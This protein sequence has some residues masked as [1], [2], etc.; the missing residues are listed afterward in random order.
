MKEEIITN[1]EGVISYE[2]NNKN[3]L[4]NAF[5]ND[6]D[7]NKAF[8]LIGLNNLKSLIINIL[9]SELSFI[10]NNILFPKH[11]YYCDVS[12]KYSHN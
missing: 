5:D 9:Y 2:F 4:E 12:V 7:N 6:C 10:M 8:K 1:I 3:L 11:Q